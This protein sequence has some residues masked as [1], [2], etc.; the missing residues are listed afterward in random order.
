MEQRRHLRHVSADL[1][2]HME[3]QRKEFDEQPVV[4]GS[5]TNLVPNI[6]TSQ[7]SSPILC[8]QYPAFSEA[9]LDTAKTLL[10]IV[11]DF[12]DTQKKN[13]C[14]VDHIIHSHKKSSTNPLTHS[15]S[16]TENLQGIA[17][18]MTK[19]EKNEQQ[20]QL[21]DQR[22]DKI[23]ETFNMFDRQQ[24]EL[25]AEL[26]CLQNHNQLMDKV[27]QFQQQQNDI[28]A[29]LQQESKQRQSVV[30]FEDQLDQGKQQSLT[31][32]HNCHQAAEKISP[33]PQQDITDSI[34]IQIPNISRMP[35]PCLP[36]IDRS[37][38]ARTPHTQL[39]RPQ[40]HI[41]GYD[42]TSISAA[43][44]TIA[45]TGTLKKIPPEKPPRASLIVQSPENEVSFDSNFVKL[46][47]IFVLSL[48][49]EF[50]ILFQILF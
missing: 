43:M 50:V 2:K 33:R 31:N 26:Q 12:D 20:Q 15:K 47:V 45:L 10:T 40:C 32:Q 16:Q 22:L 1:T 18:D 14:Q 27:V 24:S 17:C 42:T 13:E 8:R 23:S 11:T 19:Q 37:E 34:S 48:L 41:E 4:T 39:Y 35:L 21:H 44:A 29:R 7:R 46:R 36:Q 5:V 3:L 30:M 38:T 28:Q 6:V 9:K 25:H 49:F